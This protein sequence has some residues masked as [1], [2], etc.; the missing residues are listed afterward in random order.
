MQPINRPPTLD[1]ANP[2]QSTNSS[3]VSAT[4]L[5]TVREVAAALRISS[6]QVWKLL[7][8]GRLPAPVRLSRSV[9]WRASDI[10]EFIRLGCPARDRFEAEIARAGQ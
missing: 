10:A 9:R 8:S 1:R 2:T 5:L 4:Q 6:R 3:S 7:S